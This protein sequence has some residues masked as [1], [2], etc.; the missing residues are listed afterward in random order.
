MAQQSD[1]SSLKHPDVGIASL[2]IALLLWF[3]LVSL[4]S[5][6]Y[7]HILPNE[8]N[9]HITNGIVRDVRAIVIIPGAIIGVILG[10]IG[11]VRKQIKT[12]VT[13]C[14]LILNAFLLLIQ[15]E[16]WK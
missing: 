7:F 12:S 10:L 14:G 1:S 13:M 2:I 11:I 3:G 6:T 5:L 8:L 16:P 15:T 4:G 9:F